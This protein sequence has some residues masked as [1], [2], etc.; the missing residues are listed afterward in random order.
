MARACSAAPTL[1]NT[2]EIVSMMGYDP[3]RGRRVQYL[4]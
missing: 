3:G 2:P 1:S 4:L